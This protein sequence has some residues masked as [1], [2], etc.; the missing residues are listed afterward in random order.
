MIKTTCITIGM[1]SSLMVTTASAQTTLRQQDELEINAATVLEAPPILVARQSRNLTVLEAPI[2]ESQPTTA[3]QRTISGQAA[4]DH[5]VD[6]NDQRVLSQTVSSQSSQKSQSLWS[7]T[8]ESKQAE[9][10]QTATT[11][12]ETKKLKFNVASYTGPLSDAGQ[13]FAASK[14]D[15]EFRN[16]AIVTTLFEREQGSAMLPP[17]E[18]RIY[19][20]SA[21]HFYHQPLYFQ[22]INLER[23]G[24]GSRPLVSPIH[25]AAHFY[26]SMALWPAKMIWNWPTES[27]YSL[28]HQRPGDCVNYQ[29]CTWSE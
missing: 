25:T 3:P 10:N 12:P 8:D 28:G 11:Q 14:V 13:L 22:Q 2:L 21:P 5:L 29:R 15:S 19:T 6:F 17:W 18:N 27:V 7:D 1:V 4:T 26:G 16:K 24:V 23:Y 9:S 20:W